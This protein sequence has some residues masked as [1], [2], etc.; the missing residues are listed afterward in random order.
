MIKFK[1]AKRERRLAGAKVADPVVVCGDRK[2][3]LDGRTPR[4]IMNLMPPGWGNAPLSS[5]EPLV[6]RAIARGFL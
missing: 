2:L 6:L 4:D 3:V 1:I 5:W